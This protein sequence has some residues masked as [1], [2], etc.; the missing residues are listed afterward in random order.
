MSTRDSRQT[1]LQQRWIAQTLGK[2]PPGSQGGASSDATAAE[3]AQWFEQL[4]WSG[5]VG[6]EC[7]QQLGALLKRARAYKAEAEKLGEKEREKLPEM[8]KTEPEMNWGVPPWR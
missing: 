1:E 7:E 3:A 6:E 4:G 8:R 2:T 5:D